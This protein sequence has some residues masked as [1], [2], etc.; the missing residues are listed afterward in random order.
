[1]ITSCKRLRV[2]KKGFKERDDRKYTEINSIRC[3]NDVMSVEKLSLNTNESLTKDYTSLEKLNKIC[4]VNDEKYTLPVSEDLL[5]FALND[6]FERQRCDDDENNKLYSLGKNYIPKNELASSTLFS[7]F[8]SKAYKNAFS[9]L[10]GDTILNQ[11]LDLEN[12][13]EENVGIPYLRGSNLEGKKICY[14]FGTGLYY[15]VNENKN[16]FNL[17]MDIFSAMDCH[18]FASFSE[19]L[20]CAAKNDNDYFNDYGETCHINYDKYFLCDKEN[21]IND[22]E[23]LCNKIIYDANSHNVLKNLTEDRDFI[24]PSLEDKVNE[25]TSNS[26]DWNHPLD[27]SFPRNSILS[28]LDDSYLNIDKI[29][30]NDQIIINAEA[31]S[32]QMSDETRDSDFELLK[33]L[34]SNK[35]NILHLRTDNGRVSDQVLENGDEEISSTKVTFT[36]KNTRNSLG[37]TA[38]L[39]NRQMKLIKFE[40]GRNK[41]S[42]D[43]NK[44]N[45]HSNINNLSDSTI[46]TSNDN[47][48]NYKRSNKKITPSRNIFQDSKFSIR[49]ESKFQEPVYQDEKVLACELSEKL[50]ETI[51]GLQRHVKVIHHKIKDN[52]CEYCEKSFGRVANLNRHMKTVHHKIKDNLCEYCE[53]SFGRVA[54]LNRHMKTVHHKIKDNLCEYCEKSFGRVA[55]L[56]QHIKTV[57]HKIKDNL[58]EYCE[59]SFSRVADLNQHIK[60]VHQKIK[61]NLCEYCEKSFGQVSNLNRHIKVHHKI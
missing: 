32:N 53:K 26:E 55:D 28:S 24:N 59:K 12:N 6:Y 1:M 43:S 35:S 36:N 40:K 33:N 61:D 7:E 46:N 60:T 27:L 29:H 3:E 9:V 30:T 57:H 48:I 45:K 17:D 51:K 47:L 10:H 41:I 8:D 2:S 16:Y 44:E 42:L 4:I 5:T 34:V 22:N 58:C 19:E 13:E 20:L 31:L 11:L 23:S 25:N 50:F 14:S 37:K 15:K 52:L 56:N 49:N 39:K 18:K 21:I 54:H 38:T